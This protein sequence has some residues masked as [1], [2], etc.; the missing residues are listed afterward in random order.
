MITSLIKW[1]LAR[2]NCEKLAKFCEKRKEYSEVVDQY[3]VDGRGYF[4]MKFYFDNGG[5]ILAE[6][7]TGDVRSYSTADH[8]QVVDYSLGGIK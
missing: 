3:Q 4:T 8:F 2:D 5:Y 7:L 6:L 1:H